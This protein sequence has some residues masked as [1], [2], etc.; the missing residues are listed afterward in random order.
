MP[1]AAAVSFVTGRDLEAG[2]FRA[3]GQSVGQFFEA[4]RRCARQRGNA[5]LQDPS[6]LDAISTA[7]PLSFTRHAKN[8]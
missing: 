2:D 5:G 1:S 8:A 6:R 7:A 3:A 4:G